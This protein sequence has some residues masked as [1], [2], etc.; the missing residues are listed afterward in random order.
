MRTTLKVRE[1]NF[2]RF[3]DLSV[4]VLVEPRAEPGHVVLGAPQVEVGSDRWRVR[5][6]CHLDYVVV[7][8][9]PRLHIEAARVEFVQML[10]A[11]SR[12]LLTALGHLD[13]EGAVVG[14]EV[15]NSLHV[16][17]PDAVAVTQ[18]EFADRVAVEEVAQSLVGHPS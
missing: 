8:K 15:H 12:A 6:R 10:A 2:H 16:I 7:N 14:E 4:L 17:A 1:A 13:D 11:L 3:A 5:R 9:G 18:R